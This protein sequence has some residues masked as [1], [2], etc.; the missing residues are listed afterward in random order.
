MQGIAHGMKPRSSTA[1]SP[2]VARKFLEHKPDRKSMDDYGGWSPTPK[3]PKKRERVT[4]TG[5]GKAVNR[6]TNSK[7]PKFLENKR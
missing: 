1:P 6:I 5:T 7:L 4:S 3:P 2:E